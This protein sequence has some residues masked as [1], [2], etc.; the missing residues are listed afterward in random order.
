MKKVLYVSILAASTLLLAGCGKSVPK[1]GD[2]ETINLVKKI[3]NDEMIN[4]M[5]KDLAAQVSYSVEG[6][7]TTDEHDKTG[8]FECAADLK[9]IAKNGKTNKLPITYTVEATDDGKEFYVEVFGL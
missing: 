1:C 5:G 2:E 8:A 3:S 7:R 6:I 4:Q 9:L